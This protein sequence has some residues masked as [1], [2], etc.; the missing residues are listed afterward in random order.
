M[1]NEPC[2]DSRRPDARLIRGSD[3]LFSSEVEDVEIW[4]LSHEP[5]SKFGISEQLLRQN[6]LEASGL[7][8]SSIDLGSRFAQFWNS[9]DMTQ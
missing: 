8:K 2:R 9:V 1:E 4:T 3:K 7:L 5:S 6:L